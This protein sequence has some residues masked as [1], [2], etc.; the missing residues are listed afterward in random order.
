MRIW[1]THL[2]EWTTRSSLG[3]IPLEDV[4]IWDTSLETHVDGSTTTS[5]Q[6]A[7]DNDTRQAASLSLAI[8]EYCLDMAHKS[9]LVGIALDCWELATMSQKPSPVLQSESSAASFS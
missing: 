9:V 2:L 3:E 8:S 5:A 6:S 1:D 4:L 7:N